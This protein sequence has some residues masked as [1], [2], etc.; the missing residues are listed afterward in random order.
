M[1]VIIILTLLHGVYIIITYIQLVKWM[2]VMQQKARNKPLLIISCSAAKNSASSEAFDLYCGSMYQLIKARCHDF[3]ERFDCLILSA[4]HGLISSREYIDTY[5]EKMCSRKDGV[6]V[7][8]FVEKHAKSVKSLLRRAA[9]NASRLYVCVPNDYLHVL[10]ECLGEGANDVLKLFDSFYISRGHKGIGEL[11]GRLSKILELEGGRYRALKPLHFRSGVSNRVETA[12]LAAG[13]SVGTSLAYLNRGKQS[14]LYEEIL[15]STQTRPLF[16]D[17]GLISL[18]SKED[19]AANVDTEWVMSEYLALANTLPVSQSKRL[20]LVIPDSLDPQKALAIVAR[21]SESIRVL[22]RQ[23][24]VILPIHG[25][26]N[27]EQHALNMMQILGFP[28]NVKLGVPS[29]TNKAKKLDFAL[30]VEEIDRLL[31]IAHPNGKG[32]LF[33]SVHML[34]MSD[35][36]RKLKLAPRLLVA[37][38]HGLKGNQVT[39]DACRTPSIFGYNPSGKP[40]IGTK[41]A[42]IL[43][44]K[45]IGSEHLKPMV[46]EHP[47]FVNYSYQSEHKSPDGEF[48]FLSDDLYSLIE[49]ETIDV[50]W[51]MY[52]NLLKDTPNF[53]MT[54]MLSLDMHNAYEVEEAMEKAW[55]MT[56]QK[57][58]DVALF[59]SLKNHSWRS[60]VHVIPEILKMTN[61]QSRYD[62]IKELFHTSTPRRAA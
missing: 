13:C 53:R 27:I 54:S 49:P 45:M 12:Y 19:T 20:N 59:E 1:S 61:S 31:S 29:L 35:K 32:A 55:D 40:R 15:E 34:G 56:S 39:L 62:A 47:K 14:E 2:P 44:M 7:S 25:C 48:G 10:D 37:Q 36:S 51:Q 9:K 28:R 33:K 41:T 24:Q 52:D 30:T 16:V 6:A 11:R 18:Q 21:H 43:R 23:T 8:N 50:F 5:D 3:Q 4:R 42:S 58:I 57:A 22:C 26:K 38:L 60:F 46:V 17:N